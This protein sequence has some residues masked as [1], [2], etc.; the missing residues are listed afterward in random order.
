MRLHR[1]A[2]AAV[3]ALEVVALGQ[4]RGLPTVLQRA[5]VV[6]VQGS[7]RAAA[8]AAAAAAAMAAAHQ[9]FPRTHNLSAVKAGARKAAE[10]GRH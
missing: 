1:A 4:I 5:A 3:A 10:S 8:A 9:L 6:R 2:T 7:H